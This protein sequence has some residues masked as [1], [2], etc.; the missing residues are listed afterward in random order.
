MKRMISFLLSLVLLAGCSSGDSVSSE[1]KIKV[2]SLDNLIFAD[3][4]L[5]PNPD[6][7]WN[8]DEE[9]FLEQVDGAETM[10]PGNEQF[11]SLRYSYN[12]SLDAATYTPPVLY[13]L[14]GVKTE[15]KV[16]YAFCGDGLYMSGYHWVF[17]D[18]ETNAQD[19]IETILSQLNE[20]S[21]LSPASGETP[22]AEIFQQNAS[23]QWVSKDAPEQ[24]ASGQSVTLTV[25][26]M[27]TNTSILLAVKAYDPIPTEF[28]STLNRDW[29]G[30]IYVEDRVVH[31]LA[32]PE[33]YDQLARQAQQ[34]D[35]SGALVVDDPGG[36]QIYTQPQLQEAMLRLSEQMEQLH[37]VH[38]S[39]FV[40]PQGN[41]RNGISVVVDQSVSLTEEYQ[42]KAIQCAQIDALEFS[43]GT[44]EA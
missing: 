28:T 42:E 36:N 39:A 31:I 33:Y 1:K 17:A 41:P 18:D 9:T 19:G 8:L 44:G 2:S 26:R 38:L 24:D 29:H 10:I 43:V 35:P 15:A 14:K 32:L 4:T 20:I 7:S 40:H 23:C 3:D 5:V 37:I 12:A 6:F 21:F 34:F 30:G 27:R 22:T 25:S 16:S 11:D 13:Q